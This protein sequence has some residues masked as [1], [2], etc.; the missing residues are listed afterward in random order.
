V[1]VEDFHYELPE[2]LIAQEPL[3]DRSSSRMLVLYRNEARWED[4][5]FS[6]F[7]A[8]LRSGD[9][10]VLN[11]TRVFPSRLFGQRSGGTA[12]VEVF[13]I[14]ALSADQTIW[15]ALVR[16]GRKLPVGEYI[17][18]SA[19]LSAEV[20]DRG[21]HGE[22]TIR[23]DARGDLFDVLERYGHM[24]LPPYIRRPDRD[25]D[26]GRYNTVFAAVTGS[27]A[28]PTAGLHF[29]PE[30]LNACRSAGARIAYVTLHV[31][32]GTFAP[33]HVDRLEDVKLHTETYA[34]DEGVLETIRASERR[35]AVGTT[36]VRTLETVY[37]TGELT[38][39]TDI[40]ISPGYKFRAVDG[41]LTNFHLPRSSLL[42]LVSAFAGRELILEAYRHA[43]RQRYRFFSYGDC[44]LIL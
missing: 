32:L 44:M 42:M 40:F 18:F 3:A 31:G 25:E 33:L 12:R 23:L 21:E 10:L 9:A 20:L 28:A 1:L 26:R 13:L 34:V 27:V 24:P 22:R 19:D 30:V 43:V 2:E 38:G 16:P 6:D 17:S 39:E 5:C 29:T 4:R 37:A 11:D 14:R 35:I 41:M 15:Q 7:P 8:F 36:S